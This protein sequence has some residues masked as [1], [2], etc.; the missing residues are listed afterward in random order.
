MMSSDRATGQRNFERYTYEAPAIVEVPVEATL[1]QLDRM[2]LED[3]YDLRILLPQ[4]DRPLPERHHTPEEASEWAT[5]NAPFLER[6]G[7]EVF[8]G[9]TGQLWSRLRNAH[10]RPAVRLGP[11]TTA[12]NDGDRFRWGELEASMM[13]GVPGPWV[14][15]HSHRGFRETDDILNH[16]PDRPRNT[17]EAG[18]VHYASRE[19]RLDPTMM[20]EAKNAV[21]AWP[22]V[23]YHL[24]G[25][26]CRSAGGFI[27]P[28][29]PCYRPEEE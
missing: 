19:D 18:F 10:G 27:F 29:P 15:A 11:N 7:D 8:V 13:R 9:P 23:T 16:A 24:T 12:G 14:L 4:P 5:D 28:A 1:S 25:C 21:V 17:R 22:K 2:V 3:G 6:C 20:A 26:R